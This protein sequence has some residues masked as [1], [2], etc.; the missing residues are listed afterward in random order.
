MKLIVKAIL[1]ASLLAMGTLAAAAPA[2]VTT[3]SVDIDYPRVEGLGPATDLINQTLTREIDNF[4]EIFAKPEYSGKVGYK[5]ELSDDKHLSITISEMQYAYRAAHPMTYLR[6]FTFDSTTGAVLSLA[7]LFRPDSDYRAI[8]NQAMI[9]QIAK[10]EIPIFS[11]TPFT[12]LKDNQE[13]YLTA[14]SLVVYYQLY[15][16]T[17]YAFGFL[18]FPIPYKDLAG[19]LKPEFLPQ[20]TPQ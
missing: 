5:I 3:R 16:Y 18:K 17:P 8:L 9:S 6:A 13:F 19:I 14:D 1:I 4:A 20:V 11:F 12:G 2:T 7:D 15:Q 10:R